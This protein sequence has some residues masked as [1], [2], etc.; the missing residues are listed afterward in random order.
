MPVTA[1]SPSKYALADLALQSAI[2]LERIKGGVPHD[3]A[4]LD[5]L[6]ATL[7]QTSDPGVADAPFRF[8][9][10]GYYEPFERL[11][12]LRES[13]QTSAI[14]GIQEF[15]KRASEKLSHVVQGDKGLASE[16]IGFCI[17]LHQELIQEIAAEDVLVVHEWR[18]F[19]NDPP[20]GIRQA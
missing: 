11:Y 20:S 9:E 1:A 8:V 12:R 5:R 17:A 16:L 7:L 15:I 18:N 6:A 10:P 2:E 3:D 19:G 4:V 13:P 14:E